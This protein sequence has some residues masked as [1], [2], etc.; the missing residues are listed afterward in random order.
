MKHTPGSTYRLQLNHQFD[1]DEVIRVVPYLRSLGVTDIYLSPITQANPGSLHGYDVVDYSVIS[2]DLGGEKAF[3]KLQRHLQ[4]YQLNVLLDFVPNHMAATEH[5]PWWRE[6]IRKNQDTEYRGFF[7][8]N[9]R[10]SDSKKIVYRRFFDINELVCLRVEERTVFEAV[11]RLLITLI[12]HNTIQG[13]RIDHIDGLRFP[14]QYLHTLRKYLPEGF[15]LIVEKILAYDEQLSRDWLLDGTTGYDFLNFVNQVFVYPPGFKKLEAFYNQQTRN[16][17]TID[18]IKVAKNKLVLKKLFATE[19]TSLLNTMEHLLHEINISFSSK[20]LRII[21]Q[22]VSAWLPVYRTYFR[23]TSLEHASLQVLKKTFERV[24]IIPTIDA[25]LFATVEKIICLKFDK[26]WATTFQERC[27]AWV[28]NWQVFTGP[29]MAKGYEDTTCYVYNPLVSLNEVGSGPEF[30][31]AVGKKQSL[32]RFNK[33]KQKYFPLSLNASSTHDTKLSEDVRARIHVLSELTEEWQRMFLLWHELNKNKQTTMGI[34]SVSDEMRLYQVLLGAWPFDSGEQLDFIER[35]QHYFVKVLREAKIHSSWQ[36]PNVD[37]ENDVTHFCS[38]I[39]PERNNSDFHSSFLLFQQKIAFFGMLN[40]LAQTTLKLMSPG[41]PDIYQG[42]E[43][44]RFDLVDPDNRRPIDFNERMRALKLVIQLM[45]NDRLQ[46]VQALQNDWQSGHIKLFV[47]HVLLQLRLTFP[48][49][50]RDGEYIPVKSIG[51]YH[52]N[53]IAFVRRY[54][55]YSVLVV[56]PRWLTQVTTINQLPVGKMW[57]STELVTT[58]TMQLTDSVKNIF[59]HEIIRPKFIAEL[60][61]HFPIAVCMSTGE[62]V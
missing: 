58:T 32:H 19:F 36:Q 60:L 26:A 29:L 33:F 31:D 28:N 9:W 62:Q 23:N 42:N 37:Y 17:D 54:Q 57:D 5:N 46:C 44:W 22:E 12:K 27:R 24:K 43:L 18:E 38:R 8:V 48:E 13:L 14:K 4:R 50:F 35:V 6:I 41:V 1:F 51:K 45:A 49:I 15:Y 20:S 34:P 39:F 21:L 16:K 61:G 40:S 30:F 52:K 55:Q 7:D 59:T 3:R 11:H 53:I 25:R 10:D 47:I 2:A 56:V